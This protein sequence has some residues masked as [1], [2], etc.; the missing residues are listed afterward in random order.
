MLTGRL[1][2]KGLLTRAG[3]FDKDVKISGL[4][5]D[6]REIGPDMVFVAIRGDKVDGHL[7]IDKAVKNGAIA[8]VCETVPGDAKERFP[9]T[10]FATVSSSRKAWAHLSSLW[11]SDPARG[12]TMIGTTG[13]NGKSTTAYLIRHTLNEL[14]RPCGLVGTISYRTGDGEYPATLTTPDARDLHRLFRVM[15][16]SGCSACS[17][18]VS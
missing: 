1:T 16:D 13:T 6:S 10:V 2:E 7:F 18:E 11:Y 14:G 8:V 3:I 17:M 9:G 15:V 4:S 5:S 12:L